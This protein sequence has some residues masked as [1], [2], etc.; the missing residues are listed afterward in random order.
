MML[1]A[2]AAEAQQAAGGANPAENANAGHALN[3][4]MA[5]ERYRQI[6]REFIL[7]YM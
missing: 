6:L 1:T 7:K 2:A 3:F 5:P 4:A